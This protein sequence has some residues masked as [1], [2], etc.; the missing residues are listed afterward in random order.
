MA[1][2]VVAID[3]RIRNF[4]GGVAAYALRQISL[5]C[6]FRCQ[7]EKKCGDEAARRHSQNWREES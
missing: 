5:R 4:G 6:H 2:D 1:L 3:E 7:G